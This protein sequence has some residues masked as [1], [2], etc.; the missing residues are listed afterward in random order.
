V[1]IPFYAIYEVEKAS[2]E[3]Y[4]L[5]GDRY[6]RCVPNQRGHYPIPSLGVELGIW[7]GIYMN[8]PLP[9]LRWWDHAGN[10]LLAGDERAEQEKQRANQETQRADQETQRADQETQRADQADQRAEQLAAKLRELGVNPDD[11]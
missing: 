4:Q 10:L 5:I 8:Q 9:W 1:H 11:L 3:V 6:Q 2:V 7:Q